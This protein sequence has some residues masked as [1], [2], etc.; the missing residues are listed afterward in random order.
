MSV[1]VLLCVSGEGAA[2]ASGRWLAGAMCVWL[3]TWGRV[4]AVAGWGGG[5][6]GL[7]NI[8]ATLRSLAPPSSLPL[9]LCWPHL[10][11]I[12]L[13]TLLGPP[14]SLLPQAVLAAP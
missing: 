8:V 10:S 4:R 14:S 11:L 2:A 3:F 6:Q 5:G 7:A 1:C 13:V 9:R 12:P